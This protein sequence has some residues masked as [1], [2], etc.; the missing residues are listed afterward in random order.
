MTPRNEVHHGPHGRPRATTT[1]GVAG[2]RRAP[3]VDR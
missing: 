3:G 2:H 1:T